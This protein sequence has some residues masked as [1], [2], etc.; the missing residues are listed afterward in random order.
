MSGRQLADA[1]FRRASLRRATARV[2]FFVVCYSIHVVFGSGQREARK[3]Q[4]LLE[5]RRAGQPS[6]RFVDT[7]LKR[8]T[9]QTTNHNVTTDYP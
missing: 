6:G 1:V 8:P 2:S 5:V 3:K 9:L 7:V 4:M